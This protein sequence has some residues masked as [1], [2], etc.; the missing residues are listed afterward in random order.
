MLGKCWPDHSCYMRAADCLNTKTV[1]PG[2]E[3]SVIKIR[4]Y[5]TVFPGMEISL[6]KTR[7]SKTVFPGMEISLIKTRWSK[8]VFPGMDISVIK[9]R[10]SDDHL[11]FITEISIPGKTV[12]ILRQGPGLYLDVHVRSTFQLA[13]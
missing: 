6:I 10:W 11:I 5:K 1:F 4:W 8:T 13:N 2:M 7:W 9:I 3:I 12:F